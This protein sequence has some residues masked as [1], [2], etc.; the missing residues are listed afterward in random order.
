METVWYYYPKDDD[1]DDDG[2][3][4]DG[5]GDHERPETRWGG[6]A[7][8]GSSGVTTNTVS[9]TVANTTV[10]GVTASAAGEKEKRTN[11]RRTIR[12]IV[13]HVKNLVLLVL[14]MFALIGGAYYN[15][16]DIVQQAVSDGSDVKA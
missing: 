15:I 7:V 8:N 1:D 4:G 13:R 14:A 5:D 6:V 9:A 3:D 11:H 2:G 16:R 10:P 12:R